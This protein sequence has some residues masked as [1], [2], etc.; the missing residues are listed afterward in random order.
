MTKGTFFKRAKNFLLIIM[1]FVSLFLF[2][3]PLSGCTP[4]MGGTFEDDSTNKP[5]IFLVYRPYANAIGEG[6]TKS[7]AERAYD[8]LID[9]S[10]EII[11]EVVG[12]YGYGAVLVPTIENPLR[13][14]SPDTSGADFQ[15][16]FGLSSG[17]TSEQKLLLISNLNSLTSIYVDSANKIMILS[18]GGV[19]A[20]DLFEQKT[21]PTPGYY[22]KH[23]LTA[24]SSNA[25][26][27]A[28]NDFVAA[29]FNG[30]NQVYFYLSG[31]TFSYVFLGD[32]VGTEPYLGALNEFTNTRNFLSKL[33][34][35]D[36]ANIERKFVG[37][38]ELA[39][40]T[41]KDLTFSSWKSKTGGSYSTAAE[42]LQA[43]K[44]ANTQTFAVYLAASIL[45]NGTFEWPEEDVDLPFD[46]FPAVFDELGNDHACSLETLF[47]NAT[48]TGATENDQ[49]KFLQVASL[50]LDH[51]GIT[52]L[53]INNVF[54]AVKQGLIGED[55]YDESW[56]SDNITLVSNQIF[57]QNSA[58]PL[59]E[60][61]DSRVE[62]TYPVIL[63]DIAVSGYIQS[64]IIM[65]EGSVQPSHILM[66]TNEAP[67]SPD[68]VLK[69]RCNY[70]M[71]IVA[72]G[73]YGSVNDDISSTLDFLVVGTSDENG[74]GILEE[75]RKYELFASAEDVTIDVIQDFS[76]S[77][78]EFEK[79]T[80][81]YYY[82][83]YFN[84]DVRFL[85]LAFAS[86]NVYK[87]QYF[88]ISSFAFI[89][90]EE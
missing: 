51:F 37:V 26:D 84:K 64:I 57:S 41:L 22:T 80:N 90:E 34:N 67:S 75:G 36:L 21:D 1:I 38:T 74:E 56:Y 6:Q 8:N 45:T 14:L 3:F 43:Y 42:Y 66:E 71:P 61:Y 29:S 55:S 9:L 4:E 2:C 86:P 12:Y 81:V 16:L 88:D 23:A 65:T 76:F 28:E 19:E 20:A 48:K 39:E 82:A 24:V 35:Y 17:L 79:D 31:T 83:W 44:S 11:A 69:I 78:T 7:Y 5:A 10:E 47:E 70:G 53:D 63:E 77:K 52:D 27:L 40:N 89:Y 54:L 85:E 49:E 72:S 33:F 58:T 60:Y 30:L 59:L 73:Y 13:V 50:F 15:T 18:S 68:Y 25:T 46:Y 87:L 32:R 62:G